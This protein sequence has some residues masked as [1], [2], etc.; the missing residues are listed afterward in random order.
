MIVNKEKELNEY[1]KYLIE[2]G[3]KFINDMLVSKSGYL[4][5]IIYHHSEPSKDVI[6]GSHLKLYEGK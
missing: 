4:F 1:R 5:D 6:V 2:K 3:Y